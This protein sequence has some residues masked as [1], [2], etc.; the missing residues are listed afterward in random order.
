MVGEGSLQPAGCELPE[1]AEGGGVAPHA[2]V[3]PDTGQIP[4]HAASPAAIRSR[5]SAW[6]GDDVGHQQA[7]SRP[8]SSARTRA[9][10]TSWAS[11]HDWKRA[12]ASAARC[13]GD[14]N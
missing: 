3:V 12:T 6:Q 4:D 11:N 14:G 10:R 13:E 2:P 9:S 8:G 5:T 1:L 7:R